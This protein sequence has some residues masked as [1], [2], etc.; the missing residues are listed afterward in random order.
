MVEVE[1]NQ[2][3]LRSLRGGLKISRTVGRRGVCVSKGAMEGCLPHPTPACV[4]SWDPLVGPL[5]VQ[6]LVDQIDLLVFSSISTC[7]W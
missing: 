3:F 1:I 2:A 4:A 6:M 5:W 7:L